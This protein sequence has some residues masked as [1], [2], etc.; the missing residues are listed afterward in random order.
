LLLPTILG[1]LDD[2][3]S[4]VLHVTE[5]EMFLA[6]I[7]Y[8][9]RDIHGK[10]KDYWSSTEQFY[11]TFYSK[12]MR[13]TGSFICLDMHTFQTIEMVLTIMT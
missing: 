9:G 4:H 2:G 11:S 1:L 7:I 6:I 8:I 5:S 3:P 12:T 13:Y 10:L